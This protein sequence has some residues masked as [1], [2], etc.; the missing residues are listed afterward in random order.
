MID[1]KFQN[2]C[3]I[4]ENRNGFFLYFDKNFACHSKCVNV[5][6]SSA[7]THTVSDL[8]WTQSFIN[9]YKAVLL[10]PFSKSP[11]LIRWKIQSPKK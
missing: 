3:L 4:L 7:K 8:K 10:K 2:K 9:V 5:F 6:L 1:A 11:I